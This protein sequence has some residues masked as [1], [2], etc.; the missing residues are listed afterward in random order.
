MTRYIQINQQIYDLHEMLA[1]ALHA[2][3]KK[4]ITAQFT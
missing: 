2:L 1:Y 4:V 3:Y